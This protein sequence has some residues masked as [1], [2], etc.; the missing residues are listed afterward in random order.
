[1]RKSFAQELSGVYTDDEMGQ[2]DST[3]SSL[4]PPEQRPAAQAKSSQTRKAAAPAPRADANGEIIDGTITASSTVK[5]PSP[6]KAATVPENADIPPWVTQVKEQLA[7]WGLTMNALAPH[8]GAPVTPRV[9]KEWVKRQD[10]DTDPFAKL[11][12]LVRAD[13]AEANAAKGAADGGDNWVP[14]EA[15]EADADDLP[16]E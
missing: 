2:A 1:L 11:L 9:L 5:K 7:A 12:E 14:A 6:V 4:P 8:V 16:F 10:L 13:I 15:L 3:P